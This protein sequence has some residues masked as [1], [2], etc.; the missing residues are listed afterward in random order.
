M[1]LAYFKNMDVCFAP[2][3]V[4]MC[5]LLHQDKKYH[6]AVHRSFVY[7]L[8]T[9]LC[10]FVMSFLVVYLESFPGTYTWCRLINT[11]K[12]IVKPLMFYEILLI[13]ERGCSTGRKLALA[14]PL[15][16]LTVIMAVSFPGGWVFYHKPENNYWVGGP[17]LPVTWITLIVY[18]VMVM[19]SSIRL[20][21]FNEESQLLLIG[22]AFIMLNI[23]NERFIQ[24]FPEMERTVTMTAILAYYLYHRS[25]VE[26]EYRLK[27][28]KE[29]SLAR[30]Q[31]MVS[32][33]KPHFIYNSLAC[34]AETCNR[35]AVKAEEAIVTFSGYLRNCFQSLTD[36]GL[37]TFS[38]ELKTIE[39]YIELEKLQTPEK[40]N[41]VCDIKE[42]HFQVPVLSV[43][44]LV[45]NAV[46]HGIRKKHGS[47][48][49]TLKT[50]R[51][52]RGIVVSITDDG[53]GFDTEKLLPDENHLGLKNAKMRLA[54]QCGAEMRV[55]SKINQGTEITIIIPE[56]R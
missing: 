56:E 45:E 51:D 55:S 26:T 23:I 1:E 43:E 29:L 15:I 4:L 46:K 37:I 17:L 54:E 30:M 5:Y 12:Y 9:A 28:E 48:T 18:M 11:V 44:T 34:I 39:S 13:S 16:A 14:V 31:A 35:D 19:T 25:Q 27:K 2:L 22:E 40:L 42:R 36:D 24:M 41:F 32:Q 20:H 10:L 52:E 49:V 33:I 53:I 38:D 3:C 47:G 21:G 50:L 8:L 7:L 6:E